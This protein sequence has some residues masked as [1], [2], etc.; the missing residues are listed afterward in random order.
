M[1]VN[2]NGRGQVRAANPVDREV[3]PMEVI[4][5]RQVPLIFPQ[6]IP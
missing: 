1:K 6:K 3:P 5:F 4:G 2:P